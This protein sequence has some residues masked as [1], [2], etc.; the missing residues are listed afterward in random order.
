VE[1]YAEVGYNFRLSDLHAAV[2]IAQLGRLETFLAERRRLAA[3]Y[4]AAF[5]GSHALRPE[6]P[7]WATPNPQSYLVRLRGAGAAAREAV[8]DRLH[9]RGI[10]ARRGLMAVHLE[11]AYRERPPRRPLPHSEAAAASTL[12]LPLFPGLSE[13]D[14]DYVID[15]LRAAVLAALG[16]WRDA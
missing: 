16:S 13:D 11:P 12:V 9:R 10:G 15:E 3:R 5:A 4:D 2:G 6:P 7:E 1:T 14:Q 8:L